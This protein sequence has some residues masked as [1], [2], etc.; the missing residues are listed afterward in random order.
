[1]I[2]PAF[3]TL[4]IVLLS[5][6][7][8]MW[9]YQLYFYFRYMAGVQRQARRERKSPTPDPQV[10]PGVSIIVCAKN[11]EDNLQRYLQALLE[12]HYKGPFEVIVVN[13]ASQDGTQY[14]LDQYARMYPSLRL[15]FVPA[16]AWVR[17]SKKLAITLAAKAAKYDYLLLTDADCTPESDHWIES[18]IRGFIKVKRRGKQT[19]MIDVD[20]SPIDIVLGFGGYFQHKGLLNHLIQY[21]TIFSGMQYLGMAASRHP[22]MGVGRCLAYRKRT[23]FGNNG[24]SGFL[25][26]RAGDDDLFINRV[27]NRHNTQIV[28]DPA[29]VTWSIPK[30]TWKQWFEQKY[31]HMSVSPRY[32][33]SSKLRLGFEPLT[34]AILYLTILAAIVLS[35]TDYVGLTALLS[36]SWIGVGA[37]LLL[38]IRMIWQS[39]IITK[40]AHHFGLKGVGPAEATM[41]DIFFPLCNLFMLIRHAFRRKQEQKW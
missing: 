29:T 10:W 16:E 20:A 7:G 41:W 25:N 11:E 17:S 31:R 23:F 15:S 37:L 13:D 38:L 14:V 4:S 40:A 39:A 5:I 8:A 6:V 26:E 30:Q 3:N 22:Y 19:E 9:L 32:T 2:I 35:I 21:D 24:F 12:Q 27:A 36:T 18:M 1:M 33:W 28:V 34:R